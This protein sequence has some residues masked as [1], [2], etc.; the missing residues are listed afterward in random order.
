MVIA[1]LAPSKERRRL[2]GRKNDHTT[3]AKHDTGD[4]A[5]AELADFIE[6]GC[7]HADSVE[8]LTDQRQYLS[9]EIFTGLDE[10]LRNLSYVHIQDD[11]NLA[12]RVST[13]LD[14]ESYEQI[15]ATI[16]PD[17]LDSLSSYS[18]LPE[19]VDPARALEPVFNAYIDAAS[20]PPPE[21]NYSKRSEECE[22]CERSQLPLTYHHLIPRQVHAKAIKRGWAKDWEVQ[23]VAWL[24]RACHSFVHRF[25]SN[26]ELA[27]DLNTV[28]KLLEKEEI[29][30]YARWVGRIRWKKS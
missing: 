4:S 16:S 9:Q 1:R 25:A 17:V 13:P 11:S 21:H 3:V 27:R 12:A 15:F 10:Q 18:V 2:K 23:K 6:V 7:A 28:E 24:C 30:S 14:S 22:L 26:E 8:V 29:I 5:G 19:A 20:A